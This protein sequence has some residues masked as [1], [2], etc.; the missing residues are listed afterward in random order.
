MGLFPAVD[1]IPVP[2]PVWLLKALLL[3]TTSLHFA[4]V[5]LL[6][7]GLILATAWGWISRRN[8]SPVHG[9]AAGALVK[10][11]PTVMTFLINLG[12][13]P[14]LFT[15]VLYGRALYTSSVLIGAFWIAVIG[16]VMASYFLL[17]AVSRRAETGRT[18]W[19]AG[20][21]ALL[22]A[23]EVALIYSSNMTLML[24]PEAWME[25]Y[26]SSPGGT[27]LNTGDPTV[28]PRLALMLCGG[29]AAGGVGA[30]LLSR[31]PSVSEEVAGFLRKA[32]G[33]A[34]AMGILAQALTLLAVYTTQ[35]KHVHE[36]LAGSGAVGAFLFAWVVAAAA[37]FVGGLVLSRRGEFANWRSLGG[38]T[39]AAY[40]AIV[41]WVLVR[42][43]IRDA[44]L[45]A[46]GMSVTDRA[47]A[48]NW[49]VIALFLAVLIGGIACVA[50]MVR[51]LA[52][53]REGAE[54]HA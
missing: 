17:Y 14:L 1:P 46:A 34:A 25:M 9:Q 13:P 7:G 44:S 36:A 40:A 15:Q 16:L 29:V 42:D 52:V 49:G 54:S 5:Q 4:A 37:V 19:W 41:L 26:R 30:M 39:L 10:P 11:L 51:A 3:F 8:E 33:E 43:A 20:L 6:L 38:V 12:V 48:P 32:G 35:P 24:R 28:L 2:A 21:A 27:H 22:L 23:A 50:W 45:G 53:S 18:W 31:M 47:I